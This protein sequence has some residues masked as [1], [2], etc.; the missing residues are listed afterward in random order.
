MVVKRLK[1]AGRES[2]GRGEGW[3]G[4]RDERGAGKGRERE[5]RSKGRGGQKAPRR[6]EGNI[7]L[8]DSLSGQQ[9]LLHQFHATDES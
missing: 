8:R 3:T 7:A 4:K 5:R 9:T 1:T 6:S 2:E